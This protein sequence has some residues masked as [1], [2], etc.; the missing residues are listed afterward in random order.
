MPLENI[1]VNIFFCI[2]K[3][4]NIHGIFG[5]CIDYRRLPKT[6]KILH[7]TGIVI[8]GEVVIGENCTLA[9]NITIMHGAKIGNNVFIGTHSVIFGNCTIGDNATI[10][11]GAIVLKDVPENKTVIGVWKGLPREEIT[12]PL[13]IYLKND[14]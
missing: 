14:R 10:G 13:E 6:T 2:K 4:F 5:S 8:G 7:P 12:E 1:F 9:P 3:G 11:A